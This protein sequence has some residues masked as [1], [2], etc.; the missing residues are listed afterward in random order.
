MYGQTTARPDL[1]RDLERE[2]DR[3]R[4]FAVDQLL[5]R[6]TRDVLEDDELDPR[7]APRD[8]SRSRFRD[9]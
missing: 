1:E 4:P 8:R 6:L 2:V 3:E 9:G 7:P 5:E